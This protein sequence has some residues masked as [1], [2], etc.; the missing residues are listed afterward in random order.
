MG[1]AAAPRIGATGQRGSDYEESALIWLE[2]DMLI[3][4]GTAGKRSLDDFARAS[5]AYTRGR[6]QPMAYTFDDIVSTLQS[7]GRM[8]GPPSPA[9]TPG[10]P[11]QRP[12]AGLERAGWRLVYADKPSEFCPRR[13]RRAHRRLCLLVG[14]DPAQGRPPAGGAGAAGLGRPGLSSTAHRWWL[15][16][17]GLG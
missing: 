5:L 1:A 7:G 12:L 2:A 4:E 11:H 8:T 16:M 15:S 9:S 17:A 14:R 10:R 3:R 13:A 6:M